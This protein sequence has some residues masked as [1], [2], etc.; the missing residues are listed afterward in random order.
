V[1]A[2]DSIPKRADCELWEFDPRFPNRRPAAV[3]TSTYLPAGSDSMCASPQ[4]G[5]GVREQWVRWLP[6]VGTRFS[7]SALAYLAD[8]FRPLPE[9]FGVRGSWFPTLSYGLEV[10][11]APPV[12]GWEW[13]F[14]RVDMGECVAGRYDMTVVIADEEARVVAVSRHT[15]LIISAERNAKGREKL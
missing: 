15:A 3:K 11:R 6:G 7:L 14:V 12:D 5:P 9:A 13:L 10:K 4:L 8:S 1:L 2:K